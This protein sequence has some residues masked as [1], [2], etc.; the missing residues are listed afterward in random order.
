MILSKKVFILKIFPKL[1]KTFCLYSYHAYFILSLK[2]DKCVTERNK[3]LSLWNLI[4]TPADWIIE[5]DLCQILCACFLNFY[6]TER[7]SIV[8]CSMS[9]PNTVKK[10]WPVQSSE[11]YQIGSIST[12]PKIAKLISTFNCSKSA[13]WLVWKSIYIQS[14][15]S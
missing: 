6:Q 1:C 5:N 15:R 8:F 4:L 12:C 2:S 13:R 9:Y 11:K 14:Q 10:L 7:V 3:M